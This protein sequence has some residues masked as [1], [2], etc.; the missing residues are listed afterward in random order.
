MRVEHGDGPTE[1]GPGVNIELTGDEVAVAID[2]YLVAHGVHI[3]GP[4]TITVN[5]ALCESG[6][7]YIDPSGFVVAGGERYSGRGRGA[8]NEYTPPRPEGQSGE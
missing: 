1:F 2:A 5:G 8:T 7:I 6:Q 3:R 4:R